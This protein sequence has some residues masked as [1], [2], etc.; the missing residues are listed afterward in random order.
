MY[1]PNIIGLTEEQISE[2]QLTD[3]WSDKC[4]PN[5]GFI[6]NKDPTGRRNGRQ[7]TEKMQEVLT[8]ATEEAR[9]QISKVMLQ[10]CSK[11]LFLSRWKII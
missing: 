11:F 5:G 4:S 9:A 3:E 8:K 1:Q 2:L 7:P 10:K 6:E